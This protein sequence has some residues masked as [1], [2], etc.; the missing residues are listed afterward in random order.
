MKLRRE[1]ELIRGS[2]GDARRGLL[3]PPAGRRRV[4]RAAHEE[5]LRGA[6]AAAGR[7]TAVEW[8]DAAGPGAPTWCPG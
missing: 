1:R 5:R 6:I 3:D 4:H 7:N 8:G 2:V